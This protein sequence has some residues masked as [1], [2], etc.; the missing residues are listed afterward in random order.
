VKAAQPEGNPDIC[1]RE[2]VQVMQARKLGRIWSAVYANGV[3]LCP[4]RIISVACR[5]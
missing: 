4:C 1:W 3:I 5:S 2:P